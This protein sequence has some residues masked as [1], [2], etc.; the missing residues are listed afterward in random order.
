MNTKEQIVKQLEVENK[1]NIFKILSESRNF[2]LGDLLSKLDEK[3]LNEL[4][5][6]INLKMDREINPELE[7]LL[8]KYIRDINFSKYNPDAI[9]K[10]F[11]ETLKSCL[12]RANIY[13]IKDLIDIPEKK[14]GNIRKIGPK[15]VVAIINFAKKYNLKFKEEI[16]EKL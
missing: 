14:L 11:D 3:T 6:K 16:E 12:E 8:N 10:N 15:G 1:W 5:E 7:S 4:K 2:S 13:K 9:S